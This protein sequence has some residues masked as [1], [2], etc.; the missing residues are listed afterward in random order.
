MLSVYNA[1]ANIDGFQVT[2]KE[3]SSPEELEKLVFP[4]VI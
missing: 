4:F 1:D 2:L 3:G